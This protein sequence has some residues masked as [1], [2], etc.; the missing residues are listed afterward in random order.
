[1]AKNF[2][3][4]RFCV[5]SHGTIRTAMQLINDNN[6]GIV[7]VV[8]GEENL[9]TCLTD[10]DIRRALLS[11]LNLE[12]PLTDVLLRTKSRPAIVAS[13]EVSRVDLLRI[14]QNESIRQI[15]I[16]QDGKILQVVTLDELVTPDPLPARALIMAGGMGVRLRPWSNFSVKPMLPVG[17]KPLLELSIRQFAENGITDIFISTFHEAGQILEYF[18]RNAVDGVKVKFLQEEQVLGTAGSVS[19][20]PED[21]RPLFVVNGDLLWKAN[22]RRMLTE[23]LEMGAAI[24]M[25][26]VEYSH[27]VPYG[28]VRRDADQLLSIEEKPSINFEVNGGIYILSPEVC[29]RVAPGKPVH[30]TEV[31]AQ[32]LADKL[33]VRTF[34]LGDFWVDIGDPLQYLASQELLRSAR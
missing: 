32:A 7:F 34:S 11:G 22:L 17:N 19:L 9:L 8:D 29:A 13:R 4:K 2:T 26:T 25:G 10:G 27:Q 15:P 1:M 33:L 18:A 20:L 23:H 3:T 12:T 21:D 6:C 31:I 14:M 24:T 16:V 28:V 30:M 5:E